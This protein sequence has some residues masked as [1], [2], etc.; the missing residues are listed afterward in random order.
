MGANLTVYSRLLLAVPINYQGKTVG[1]LEV[2]YRPNILYRKRDHKNIILPDAFLGFKGQS[3][4]D[5]S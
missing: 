3:P 2:T 5:F 4:K 1:V